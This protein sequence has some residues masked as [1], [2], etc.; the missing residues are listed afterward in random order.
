LD[1]TNATL[2]VDDDGCGESA[3]AS[4][5]SWQAAYTGLHYL[6]GSCYP[7]APCNSSLP[8][9][10][11]G[12]CSSPPGPP[13]PSPQP[14]SP[15]P[16]P[17]PPSPPP[18]NPVQS[19][20]KTTGGS[21]NTTSPLNCTVFLCASQTIFV[22]QCSDPNSGNTATAVYSDGGSMLA[23]DDDGCGFPGGTSILTYTATSNGNY[24]LAGYC[25]SGAT[26]QDNLTYTLFGSCPS[27]PAHRL[28]TLSSHARRLRVGLSTQLL[29]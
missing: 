6:V 9:I 13:P 27:P 18:P 8:Y 26:C 3:G 17:Q 10:I 25:S 5:I 14:P 7:G 28:P 1:S 11:V 12:T 20:A 2:A 19:R 29:P 24:T 4:S 22:D 23:V 21:F 16:S 15:P